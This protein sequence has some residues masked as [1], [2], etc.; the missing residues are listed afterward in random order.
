MASPYDDMPFDELTEYATEVADLLDKP[1]IN[2]YLSWYEPEM[3]EVWE[4][5]PVE[6]MSDGQINAMIDVLND[7]DWD[8]YGWEDILADMDRDYWEWFNEQYGTN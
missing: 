7:N 6:D 1:D 2:D 5:A 4:R 3:L 8:Q